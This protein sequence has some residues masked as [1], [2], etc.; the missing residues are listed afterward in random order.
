MQQ[1]SVLALQHGR[2]SIVVA[3]AVGVLL[4][5]AIQ[6]LKGKRSFWIDQLH[7]QYGPYVRISPSE[8]DVS[9]AP[10]FYDIHKIGSA[11]LKSPWYTKF[12]G[13]VNCFTASD[14]H[15]HSRKRKIL[16]RPFSKTSLRDSW[17][18]VVSG[19]S[20]RVVAQIKREAEQGSADVFL[21]W[22]YFATDVIGELSFSE[23]FGMVESGKK[24]Q[25][26]IDME[27]ITYL[28]TLRSEY[29]FL[30]NSMVKLSFGYLD[31][32]G[33]ARESI[34]RITADIIVKA[35]ERSLTKKNIFAGVLEETESETPMS[36]REAL[37]EA[38]MLVVAGS[39]T[40][41]VTLTYLVWAVMSN[42]SIQA[43]L[44]EEV[45]TLDSG[46]TDAQLE[47]LPFLN[48]VIQETLRLYGAAPFGTPRTVP[49]GG[50]TVGGQYHIPEGQT[51]ITQAYTFHRDPSMYNHPYE[52]IPDRFIDAKLDKN[53]VFAP[54]GAGSRTCLG[55]H[56]A[57]MELR[58]AAATFFRECAGAKLHPSTTP[59][60][61]KIEQF[62]LIS[63]KAKRCLITLK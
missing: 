2:V 47:A 1:L 41:A 61:M 31:P 62:A 17:E 12:R 15:V 20:Q 25:F 63:P 32:L 49:K 5:Y 54:F 59:E 40:T 19:F 18:A 11:F 10:S 53:I 26:I 50:Y 9:D 52:F 46:F 29:P 45:A 60:S 6:T 16:A 48:A 3:L 4:F 35:R 34:D 22:T 14:P 38:T 58:H 24:S 21:W 8:V 36:E 30:Y 44:E 33:H 28:S 37:I 13:E 42:P 51:I 56:L 23:S 27:N 39:G 7:Q 43:R 57:L 55:I